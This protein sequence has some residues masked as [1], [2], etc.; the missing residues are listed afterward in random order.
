MVDENQIKQWL[1]E[2]TITKKQADKMLAD[3]APVDSEEKSNNFVYIIATIGA[4]LIFV[5]FAWLIAKN[6]HQIPSLFK[7]FILVCSTLAAFTFGVMLKQKEHEGVGRALIAL[8]ALLFILSLFLISQTYHLASSIQHYAWILFLA[9]TVILITAYFLDSPENLVIAMLTFFNWVTIQYFASISGIKN[10][11]G[12]GYILSIILIYLGSGSLLFGLSSLHSS[13]KHKFTN[14][15][16]FWTVFY[17]LAI[18][19]LLSFQSILP[20]LS[21]YSFEEETFTLFIIAFVI[22][23]FLGFVI[24]I[25]FASLKEPSSYKETFGFI[26]ILALLFILILSSKAGAS[27]MGTCY[28]KN[29]YDFRTESECIAAPDPLVCKWSTTNSIAKNSQGTCQEM[30]CYKYLNETDCNSPS[31]KLDCNWRENYC[32]TQTP[33]ESK[34]YNTCKQFNNQE[35]ICLSNSLCRWQPSYGLFYS[36]KGLPVILWFFWIINNIIFIGFILLII[37]YG[38]QKGSS[39]IINL[40]LFA[41]IIEIISRYIGFWL[42]LRGYFA[43]SVL[44]I[45]GGLLLIFG[46]WLI[47]KWRRKLLQQAKQGENS[48]L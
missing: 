33:L 21:E 28:P 42:D 24:G 12:G 30:S 22:L 32:V 47:P 44:A 37:W 38:Q 48:D 40:A 20:I 34:A 27:L 45:L 25:I 1:K 43:F 23:C 2:G 19:Y 13:L 11:S 26:G 14:I 29:C 46:A 3:S 9:W 15:Y 35:N 17:F 39:K 8:G 36:Q 10:S 7:V 31:D 18:F 41:F 16:R 5:G 4:I 6:W